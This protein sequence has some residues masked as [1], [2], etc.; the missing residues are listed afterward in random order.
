MRKRVGRW[1]LLALGVVGLA[2]GACSS[3]D[4]GGSGGSTAGP[5]GAAAEKCDALVNKICVK[6]GPCESLSVAD[7]TSQVNSQFQQNYGATCYGADQVS[8]SYEQCL[9]DLDGQQCGQSLPATCTGAILFQ[10]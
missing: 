5:K 10:Q 6:M 4:D 2:A 9:T 7:C 3:S 1:A 8:S